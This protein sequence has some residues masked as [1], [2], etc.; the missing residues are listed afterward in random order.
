MDRPEGMDALHERLTRTPGGSPEGARRTNR[1]LVLRALHLGGPASRAEL[2]KLL[3]VTPATMSSVVREL[4]DD[5][6]VEELGRSAERNVG[7]PATLIGIRADG[8]HTVALDLS[9]SDRFDGALVDLDGK[10]VERR[11]IPRRDALGTDALA[12]IVQLRDE[13]ID[14]SARPV[15]GVGIAS[16]GYVDADG[17]ITN[18]THLRWDRIDLPHELRSDASTPI[19]VVNDANASALAE[20]TYGPARSEDLLVVRIDEGVGAGLVL[21]GRLHPG[22]FGGGREI[23]HVVID[24]VGPECVCGKRGCLETFV[25]RAFGAD[26][27]GSDDQVDDAGRALG[28]GLAMLLS[29]TDVADVVL[30]G[31]PG[32]LDA[33]FRTAVAAAIT[34]RTLPHLADR[35]TV[36]ATSFHDTDVLLGAAALV[37]DREFGL[38]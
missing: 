31:P 14:L 24:P 28:T 27:T 11:S 10:I 20:L 16:P 12:L 8:R 26:A 5:E 34:Q 18:A 29:A 6:L 38:R 7:K 4:I 19:H 1:S 30:S 9:P 21:D 32:V 35:I 33:P 15:A 25:T 36:R 37:L 13:L 17:V 3:G 2:A 22:A 23:G